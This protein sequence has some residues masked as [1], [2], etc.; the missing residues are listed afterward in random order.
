[1]VY[2]HNFMIDLVLCSREGTFLWELGGKDLGPAK[3]QDIAFHSSFENPVV[4]V[5]GLS[6]TEY[7][8]QRKMPPIF[9]KPLS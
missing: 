7:L 2:G 5:V 3:W 6:G 9:P 1:M 4:L 8:G